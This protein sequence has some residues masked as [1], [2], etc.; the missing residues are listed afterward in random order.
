MSDD[1]Q[2][3][4]WRQIAH[5]LHDR[6]RLIEMNMMSAKTSEAMDAYDTAVAAENP[7][8]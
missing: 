2:L 5:D 4:L 7:D 1:D 3:E 8:T 6:L